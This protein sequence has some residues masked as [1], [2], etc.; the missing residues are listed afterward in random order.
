MSKDVDELELTNFPENE[1]NNKFNRNLLINVV[2]RASTT[3]ATQ[4]RCT[5][6]FLECFSFPAS[7]RH[8]FSP[9]RNPAVLLCEK[10]N[11]IMLEF[12]E[13]PVNIAGRKGNEQK[14]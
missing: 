5:H 7:F 9:V 2:E 12:N 1:Q 3:N 10:N 11:K 6:S 8:S 4:K 14:H 13:L